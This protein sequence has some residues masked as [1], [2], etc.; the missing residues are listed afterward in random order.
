MVVKSRKRKEKYNKIYII[1]KK[2]IISI[3]EQKL[4]IYVKRDKEQCILIR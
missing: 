2:E 1:I 3:Q 4:C